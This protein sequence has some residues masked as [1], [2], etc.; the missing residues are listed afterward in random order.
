MFLKKQASGKAS[1]PRANENDKK[2]KQVIA[3][4]VP[5]AIDHKK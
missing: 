5:L 3:A 4:H 2:G 1:D